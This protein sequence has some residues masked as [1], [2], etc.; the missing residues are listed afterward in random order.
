MPQPTSSTLPRPSRLRFQRY[1][2]WT[3]SARFHQ[4]PCSATS[5]SAYSSLDVS[6]SELC[7]LSGAG[8]PMLP[9]SCEQP[10]CL[11]LDGRCHSS[12]LKS[13]TSR[14]VAKRQIR[15]RRRLPTPSV[16]ADESGK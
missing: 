10:S 7:F 11:V 9:S 13:P 2:A 3:F 12:A 16:S 6:D 4:T 14:P 5:L 8:S 1:G 15:L